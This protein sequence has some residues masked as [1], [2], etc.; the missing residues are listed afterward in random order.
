MPISAPAAP[1]GLQKKRKQ[2]PTCP[3]SPVSN[4]LSDLPDECSHHL[5]LAIRPDHSTGRT[6]RKKQ[7]P[8]S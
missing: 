1:F 6:R 5:P 2:L 3:F 4:L 8:T 7:G